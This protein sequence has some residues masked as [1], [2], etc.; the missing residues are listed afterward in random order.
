MTAEAI[1]SP[2]RRRS[3]AAAI[4]CTSVVGTTMGLISPL[5]SLILDR[6]GIDG[7]TIGFNA[8]SQSLA[9]LAVSPFAPALISRF[10]MRQSARRPRK[11]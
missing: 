9:G 4:F 8:A 1:V 3:L 2:D 7:Q 11:G 10:G 6:H 5:L